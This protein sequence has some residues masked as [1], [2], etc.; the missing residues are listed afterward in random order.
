M[1]IISL[2]EP[3]LQMF[4]ADHPR[5]HNRFNLS[6]EENGLRIPI[7][8]RLQHFVPVEKSEIQF[9][10]IHFVIDLESRLQIVI[11]QKLARD[12]TKLFG[13]KT[14]ILLLNRQPG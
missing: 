8:E 4:F 10:E 14:D 5:L 1:V 7:A 12:L 9:R 3:Q 6:R 2:P 11:R 13:K